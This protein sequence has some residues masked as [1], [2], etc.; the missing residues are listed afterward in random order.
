MLHANG[1]DIA[2]RS[3]QSLAKMVTTLAE[4]CTAFGLVEAEEKTGPIHMRPRSA[5]VDA[6]ELEVGR[7]KVQAR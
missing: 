5:K 4:L 7:P 2:S 3:R 6:V 1:A